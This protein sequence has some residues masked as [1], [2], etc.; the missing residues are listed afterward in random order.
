MQGGRNEVVE[1]VGLLG[2]TEFAEHGV[3]FARRGNLLQLSYRDRLPLDPVVYP[4][5]SRHVH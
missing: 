5:R 3:P 4:K 1:V 2:M